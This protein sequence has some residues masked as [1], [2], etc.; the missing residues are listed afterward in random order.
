MLNLLKTRVLSA[1]EELR[2]LQRLQSLESISLP[3]ITLLYKQ[4]CQRHEMAWEFVEPFSSF[5]IHT[6]QSA[7]AKQLLE[8]FTKTKQKDVTEEVIMAK[9][10]LASIALSEKRFAEGLKI[11]TQLE[12]TEQ[13]PVLILKARLLEGMEKK[14]MQRLGQWKH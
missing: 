11:L 6:N 7:S 14:K 4:S 13:A 8:S 2:I 5:L 10:I 12:N 3:A 9:S 1:E